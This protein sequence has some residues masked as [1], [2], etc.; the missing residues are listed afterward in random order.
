M[1]NFDLLQ[2]AK[3]KEEFLQVLLLLYYHPETSDLAKIQSYAASSF[4]LTN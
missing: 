2:T 3:Q 4:G 1:A